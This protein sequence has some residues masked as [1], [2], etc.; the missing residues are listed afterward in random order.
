[1]LPN[2]MLN[3]IQFLTAV[4]DT[5][6]LYAA[7]YRA[8]WVVVSILL[9][10]FAS[11]AALSASSRIQ[12]HDGK[13]SNLTWLFISALALGAGT[14]AMNFV[15]MIA[16]RLPS[17][18]SYDPL[19]TVISML[20]SL[21]AGSV[22]FGLVLRHEVKPKLLILGSILLGGGI[23]SMHYTGMTAMRF[24]G[25]IQYNPTLFGLSIFVAIAL[26][27]LALY[28]KNNNALFK[29]YGNI[30]VALIL[31]S[32]F[33]GMHY[34]AMAATYF[35]KSEAKALS[36]SDFTPDSL[37]IIVALTTIF[38]AFVALALASLS[39]AR[40]VTE[41]LRL[42]ENRFQ[43][44]IESIPD[45]ICLKDAENRLLVTNE[46][47]KR[48]YQLHDI[49]WQGKSEAELADINPKFYSNHQTFFLGDAAT[50]QAGEMTVFSETA[51][52]QD[53]QKIDIEVR[54]VPVYDERGRP[55]A[56][57]SIGRD[58][59]KQNQAK[60]DLSVAA[61]A[62]EAQES[63]MVLDANRMILRVNQSFTMM[64]GFPAEEVIGKSV[65]VFRADSH[66]KNF[67][68][69]LWEAVNLKGA[70]QGEIQNKRKS[71]EIYTGHVSINAVK[72]QEGVITNYV[73]TLVD[74][75]LR[76]ANEEEIQHLAYY[77][78]LT[79]LPNRRLLV[80]R[81][82]QATAFSARNGSNGALLFLD[83]DHFKTL[84]DTLG[85][86]FGDL[87]L[88]QV[89]IRLKCCVREYDT[90]ARIGGD[91]FVVLLEGLSD[92]PIEATMQA[93]SIVEKILASLNQVYQ[94]DSYEHHSTPSIGVTLFSGHDQAIDDL[95]KQADIAMYQAKKNGRNTL[96][97]FNPHMQD[98][99]NSK[100]FIENE[101]RKA[102]EKQ[103]FQLHYQI[104]VD[105]SGKT[106][107]A[108][109]L[110]RWL[111]PERGMISPFDF[112]PMAEESGL[113]LP[114][115][116]WVLETACL[117]LK[118][119]QQFPASSDLVLAVNVSAKQFLQANFVDQVKAVIQRHGI[120]S[121]RL[122]LELTESI[123]LDNI[124]HI[125]SIMITLKE[126]GIQFSL[127]DFGTGYSSLQYLKKLPLNQL[128]IDQSFIRDIL[129]D[130]SDKAIVG[131]IISMA[132]NL[133]LSVIAEGVETPEQQQLLL[134]L[135]CTH[136]QGYLYSKPVSISE[137]EDLLIRHA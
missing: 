3:K 103:Q 23:G 78:P 29:Q 24:E 90:V 128:K 28:V 17:P 136:Y 111:H 41:T 42:S 11:Y 40:E 101:L 56:L 86:A 104:Q 123:L 69:E 109:A 65:E 126:F 26:S 74:I 125:I 106:L 60:V 127:D 67:Y 32:A 63:M 82:T 76:K 100:A 25:T 132:H 45:A 102:I 70:W 35:T 61:I 73:S 99:I 114:I 98:A 39:R 55:Q 52:T 84:N 96:R 57:V 22:V 4:P 49:S 107:G 131:T 5:S 79:Q 85:H 48:L 38:L 105:D 77:E 27:Y 7:S 95:L 21:L 118:V 72:N 134:G 68:V 75:T 121:S 2:T 59:T 89:A 36:P 12:G 1:M 43:S 137:F 129:I 50:W 87:L 80:D 112:I 71:G 62:F 46:A 135:G 19:I 119:W 93:E 116:E 10:I 81:L 54:K 117:Q 16:L 44:M 30:P 33:S 83:L 15:G 9:A 122:K 31:G 34:T 113:I 124:D 66:E 97:F 110:I 18:I 6:L 133:D 88:Q 13:S 120:E 8:E 58:V 47:A 115:G 37:A 108:E 92:H 64:T 130:Q 20:P 94:L 91:E 14:W 53:N 51:T